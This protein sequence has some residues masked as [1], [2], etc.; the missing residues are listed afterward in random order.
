MFNNINWH[1][2]LLNS[3]K[4]EYDKCYIKFTDYNDEEKSILCLGFRGIEYLGQYDE[5]VIRSIKLCDD[6]VYI[7]KVKT[8]LKNNNSNYIDDELRV[9]EIMLID[10]IKIIVVALEFILS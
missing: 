4:I 3:I 9:L 1:D 10:N 2:S 8:V 5:N 6:S 7:N